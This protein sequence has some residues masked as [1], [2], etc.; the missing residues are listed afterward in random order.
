[1]LFVNCVKNKGGT[2]LY[3]KK[4]QQ[5]PPKK[6]TTRSSA[7][8]PSE[9]ETSYRTQLETLQLQREE[10]QAVAREAQERVLTAE[11]DN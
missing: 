1:M 6:D 2:E 7:I 4:K 9:D 5:M 8:E 10:A 11:E 3:L